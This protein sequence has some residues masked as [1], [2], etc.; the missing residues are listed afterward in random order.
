VIVHEGRVEVVSV[1][2]PSAPAAPL[3]AAGDRV[4]AQ[5]GRVAPAERLEAD[6][7]RAALA[8]HGATVTFLDAPLALVAERFNRHNALQL[9]VTDPA[10]AARRIGGT[11][12][13]DRPEA[14]VA[15]FEQEGDV[16]VDR[17]GRAGAVV[18][19][20]R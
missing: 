12:S 6:A 16:A 18:L 4:R 7:L 8:W 20:R 9:V 15:L 2:A 17:A 10:L 13:L 5:A 11:F 14:L 3:L 19:R 1:D